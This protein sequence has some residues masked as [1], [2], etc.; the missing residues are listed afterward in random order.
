MKKFFKWVLI[1]F[2]G[3]F[4]LGVILNALGVK[5]SN[6]EN[7][8]ENSTK[9][10][11]DSKWQYQEDISKMTDKKNIYVTLKS[12][13]IWMK[14]GDPSQ[15]IIPDLTFRCQDD[16][17]DVILSTQTPLSPEYGNAL[18]KTIKAR[19]DNQKAFNISFS[20]GQGSY[21]TFF[22]EK[23]KQLI[24]KL[25]G[26]KKLLLEVNVHR[27]GPFVIEFNLDEFEKNLDPV[28]KSCKF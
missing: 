11:K 19:L 28:K 25:K 26:H 20:N 8:T 7:K 6:T 14:N 12:D 2:I 18:G 3:F 13:S 22:A 1:L 23:P 10:T 24:E 9:E 15:A 5:G 21:T 16:S 17:V 4:L 27:Q